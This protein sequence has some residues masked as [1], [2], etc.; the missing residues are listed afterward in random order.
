MKTFQWSADYL[1]GLN[2]VDQQHH[3]LVDLINQ[4]GEL[5]LDNQLNNQNVESLLQ[6]LTDYAQYHF[7]EEECLMSTIGIDANYFAFHHNEHETFIRQVLHLTEEVRS[8]EGANP[9]HLLYFLTHWLGYHILGIDQNM[10][11]QIGY[12]QDGMS[13]KDAFHTAEHNRSKSMGP[14]LSALTGLFQL[15]SE[16]NQVL[17]D[18]NK[19]LEA[20]VLERTLALTEANNQLEKFAMTDV[21]TELPNRRF[22]MSLLNQLWGQEER[23]WLACMM[24]DA[25]GFKHI[26]DQ[27]GHAAGD[28]VLQALAQTLRESVRTDDFVCRLGGDEFLIIC[29]A[30]P[31][32][33]AMHL[34]ES[35]RKAVAAMSVPAGDG[36]WHGSISV[37]VATTNTAMSSP[38]Q[39]L[40]AADQGVYQAKADGRNCVRSGQ[41]LPQ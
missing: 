12:I 7:Q 21:L 25:D 22:A 29:L 33:G 40:K 28:R 14:L 41:L 37:G 15:L 39:L 38:D 6:E 10:A 18:L 3:K 19:T 26:N 32:P 20:R 8:V 24:I 13:A 2:D 16:R 30:T 1:T 9:K 23:A 11:E 34:A 27:Y 4:F 5:L 35:V 36:V 31:L 17:V